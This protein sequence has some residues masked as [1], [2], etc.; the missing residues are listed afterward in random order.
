MQSTVF[1][2]DLSSVQ[3]NMVLVNVNNNVVT[4]QKFASRLR[5]ICDDND[6]DRII[7]KCLALNDSFVRFVLSYEITDSQLTSAI[8][9][10]KYVIEKLKCSC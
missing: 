9:K 4:A 10:I 7:V 3:T 8:K 6:E 1:S 2:V 5:E